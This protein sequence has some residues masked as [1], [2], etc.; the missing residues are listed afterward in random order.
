MTPVRTHEMHGRT[1]VL[2]DAIGSLELD[3]GER[4][5]ITGSHGGLGSARA[6][7]QHPPLLVV[8][9]DAGV[10]KD[11][12]GTAGLDLLAEFGVAAAT[13]AAD[14]A[15]IGDAEDTLENG[16]ISHANEPARELG[17][18]PGRSLKDALMA[19]P[20]RLDR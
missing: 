5:V 4:I 20:K 2:M 17:L 13:V 18:D 19:L 3:H 10:G 7:L 12:A 8:F 14:S 15:R 11:S 1:I 9:N 16:R 6:A